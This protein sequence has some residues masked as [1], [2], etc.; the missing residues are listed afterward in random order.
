[1]SKIILSH[2]ILN[3]FTN[4]PLREYPDPPIWDARGKRWLDPHT[5]KPLDPKK[6]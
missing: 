3:N 2:K 5:K 1:M 4:Y 6:P